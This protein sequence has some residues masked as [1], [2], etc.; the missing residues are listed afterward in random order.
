MIWVNPSAR[1][2]WVAG[3]RRNAP[4]RRL[5]ACSAFPLLH[6]LHPAAC[7][8]RDVGL[9]C[10]VT[11]PRLSAALP[12]RAS[13]PLDAGRPATRYSTVPGGTRLNDTQGRGTEPAL[14]AGGA[15]CAGRHQRRRGGG[16]GREPAPVRPRA[17]RQQERGGAGGGARRPQGPDHEGGAA[18][19]HHPRGAAARV[20]AGAVPAAVA[21]PAH[22][23]GVRAPA[24]DGRAGARLGRPLQ[25]LRAAAG[26][27]RVARPGASRGRPRRHARSPPSC[28]I[29]TC[30]RRWRRT[31]PSSR[32]CSPCTR[33]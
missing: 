27:L 26:G 29:P 15:L 20:R 7:P 16:P 14:G 3:S 12:V 30:S 13:C 11:A 10:P 22:G 1:T 23:A 24:H 33:A 32:W 19:G 5:S 28:S 8:Y 2:A 9:S 6:P 31:S 17:R 18:A 21:G 25:E 4:K